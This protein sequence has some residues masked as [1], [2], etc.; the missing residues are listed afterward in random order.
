MT[1]RTNKLFND[2]KN[3]VE[4]CSDDGFFQVTIFNANYGVEAGS[5]NLQGQNAPVKLNKTEQAI[6]EKIVS[7]T[8]ITID[9]LTVA[10]G[11]DRRTIT[12]NIKTLKE[13]GLIE[14]VSSDKTG[15]WK[16]N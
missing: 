16:V 13:K 1:D 14:R 2:G 4:L 6:Y 8:S 11:K 7:N 10:L 12:H 3:H 5:D 9:E 15:Y